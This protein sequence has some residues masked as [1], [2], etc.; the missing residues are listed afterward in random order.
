[1]NRDRMTANVKALRLTHWTRLVPGLILTAWILTSCSG[2]NQQ[3]AQKAGMNKDA[4]SAMAGDTLMLDTQASKLGWWAHKVTGEHHGTVDIARG[5]AVIKDGQLVGG[6]AIAQMNTIT[7]EDIESPEWNAKLVNHL[8]SDDFF[9]VEKFPEATLSLTKLAYGENDSITVTADL[10]IKGIT[11]P[12]TFPLIV[13]ENTNGTWHAQGEVT[14]DRTLW[15]IRYRSGK[16][17]PDIGDKLIYDD[18]KLNFD[19]QTLAKPVS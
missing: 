7:D 8:K 16:F 12:V 5:Y 10:T 4:Q 3:T 2:D 14:V 15:D 13:N 6:Q 17:F 11:H 1:M 9:M 19:L 18:F